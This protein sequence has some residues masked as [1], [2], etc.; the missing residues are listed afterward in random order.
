MA[1]SL[2]GGNSALNPTFHYFSRMSALEIRQRI[3]YFAMEH[4]F[5]AVDVESLL[6]WPIDAHYVTKHPSIPRAFLP[7]VC[8]SSREIFHEAAP[9]FIANCS[10]IIRGTPRNEYIQ[11]FSNFLATIANDTGFKSVR[12]LDFQW[13]G[14]SEVSKGYNPMPDSFRD[15]ASL[16]SRC[17]G[18]RTLDI[19]L[20]VSLFYKPITRASILQG[21]LTARTVDEVIDASLLGAVLNCPR[22][23][24]ISLTCLTDNILDKVGSISPT[25]YLQQVETR[26]NLEMRTR[27]MGAILNTKLGHHSVEDDVECYFKTYPH[28]RDTITSERYTRVFRRYL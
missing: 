2:G 1:T 3:Y 27:R 19:T 24:L 9:V 12:T 6:Y 18:L 8:C 25:D 10:F 23:R 7:R 20:S 16:I 22:I 5:C 13:C 26:L 28:W 15:A 11:F 4:T 21:S 17:T 14:F